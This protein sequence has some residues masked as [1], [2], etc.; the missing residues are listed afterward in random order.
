MTT[1][2]TIANPRIATDAEAGAASS[3]QPTPKIR[4]FF[5]GLK[6]D[7]GKLQKAHLSLIERWTKANGEVVDTHVVLYRRGYGHFSPEVW[8][9]FEVEN[10]TDMQSDY[11]ETDRIRIPLGHPLFNAALAAVRK[12]IERDIRRCEKLGKH[13]DA[14]SYRRDEENVQAVA[15]GS[16]RPW[17][18]GTEIT[19]HESANEPRNPASE[20]WH[21]GDRTPGDGDIVV[22]DANRLVVCSLPWGTDPE[23]DALQL[24]SARLLAA[25]PELLDALSLALTFITDPD[26]TAGRAAVE[27]DI[28]VA[29]NAAI[30]E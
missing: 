13:D 15:A 6:V 17:E 23:G 18:S 4:F 5:N 11:F 8:E 2:N 14:A 24:A 9:L 21:V 27:R 20:R 12:G 26:A 25:A 29:L 3:G 7:G 30:A 28:N 22:L 19:T 1:N 16:A 10:N